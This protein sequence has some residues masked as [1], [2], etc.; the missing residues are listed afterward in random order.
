MAIHLTICPSWPLPECL[1]TLT[2][3]MKKIFKNRE[4][5][6][7][8]MFLDHSMYSGIIIYLLFLKTFSLFQKT[9][10]GKTLSCY[11]SHFNMIVSLN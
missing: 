7:S 4:T 11:V 3:N 2:S 10:E 9:K 6:L 8:F 5:T 1:H